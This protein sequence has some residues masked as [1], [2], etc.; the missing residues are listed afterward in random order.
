MRCSLLNVSCKGG[1]RVG[2]CISKV[3]LGMTPVPIRPWALIEI[4]LREK[5]SV[6][7]KNCRSRDEAIGV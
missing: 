1:V 7:R 4:E 2:V 3:I 5:T 6:T